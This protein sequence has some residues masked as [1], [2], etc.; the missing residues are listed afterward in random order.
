MAMVDHGF[1][2]DLTFDFL[3]RRLIALQLIRSFSEQK[4]NPDRLWAEYK[5]NFHCKL[6]STFSSVDTCCICLNAL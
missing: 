4:T 2:K 5:T 1:K 3:L 6:S